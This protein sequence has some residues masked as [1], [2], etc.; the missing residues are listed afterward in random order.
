MIIFSDPIY[1]YLGVAG[2]AVSLLGMIHEIIDNKLI[3][4]V[5]PI[6]GELTKALIFG[7]VLT[8]MVFM[9]LIQGGN[10]IV[11]SIL[12]IKEI[13][14]LNSFW[15]LASVLI[16]WYVIPLWSWVLEIGKRRMKK[17]GK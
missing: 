1:F 14:L 15:F 17:D 9:F 11:F 8:P 12:G 13:E 7:A 6:I 2:G 4:G 10:Q 16:S 3:R 5:L